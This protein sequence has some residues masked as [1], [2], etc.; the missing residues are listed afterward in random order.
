MWRPDN[1]CITLP[2]EKILNYQDLKTTLNQWFEVKEFEEFYKSWYHSNNTHF[3]F[4]FDCL[5]IINCLDTNFSKDLRGV[6][7][8]WTQAVVY[9]YIWLKFNIEVPHNDYSNWFT[10]TSDIVTM[11]KEQGVDID[12]I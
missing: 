1:G 2:I 8:I 3:N 4:Y 9:Y 10:N 12:S 7:D 6:T 5:D 11:L